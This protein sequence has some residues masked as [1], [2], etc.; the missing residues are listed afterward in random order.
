MYNHMVT[1]LIDLHSQSK[2]RVLLTFMNS[3]MLF[4]SVAFLAKAKVTSLVDLHAHPKV[5]SF[6]LAAHKCPSPIMSYP[7]HPIC[8][9]S[10]GYLPVR[11]ANVKKDGATTT[12]H[13]AVT[14]LVDLR[15]KKN[16]RISRNLCT[17]TKVTQHVPF[18]FVRAV[19]GVRLN[20]SGVLR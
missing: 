16:S 18:M 20:Q 4:I 17:H 19:E 11:S 9:I 1:Y 10:L 6:T 7:I 3:R 12:G 8:T 2:S 15:A 13:L 5:T 14:S